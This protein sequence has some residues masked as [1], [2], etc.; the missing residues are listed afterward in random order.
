MIGDFERGHVVNNARPR[1]RNLTPYVSDNRLAPVASMKSN[2]RSVERDNQ[3]GSRLMAL[4]V[5]KP[6]TFSALSVEVEP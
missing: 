4:A 3:V 6:K 2:K 1:Q 5:F